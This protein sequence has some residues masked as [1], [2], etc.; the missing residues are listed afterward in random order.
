MKG[1]RLKTI[2]ATL[3]F[4]DVYY[5]SKMFKRVEGRSPRQFVKALNAPAVRK[6]KQ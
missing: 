2:A 4:S 6:R 5:L 1:Q 3:G